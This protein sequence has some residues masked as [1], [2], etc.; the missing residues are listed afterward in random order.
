[1]ATTDLTRTDGGSGTV[2]VTPAPGAIF[3]VN[4][5]EADGM[6]VNVTAGDI[7]VH[8]TDQGVNYDST[9]IGDGTDL[10]AINTDGSINVAQNVTAR[11]AAITL[12]VANGST[13]GGI[14]SVTFTT[15]AGFT[16][17]IAGAVIPANIS[18]SVSANGND[19]INAIAYTITAGSILITTLT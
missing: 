19:T 17:T 13:A 9:R 14:Q 18:L 3:D 2:T 11:T 10:L 5:A 8:L 7:N 6:V 1:M 15:S 16:G 12:A 4:L